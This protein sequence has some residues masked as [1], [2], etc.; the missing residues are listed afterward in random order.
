MPI[1]AEQKA[2]YP[3]DWKAISQR[4]RER[5]ENKCKTCKAPNGQVV[6][7]SAD[8]T[9][10]M[11]EEGQ[12]FSAADGEFL[13][14]CKGSEYNGGNM[15][16]IVLTVAH[17]DHDP[18]NNADDNLAALCQKCHLA[19]DAEHHKANANKTRRGRKAIGELF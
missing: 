2:L 4:I 8:G 16:K 3:K 6:W 7:R 17:L 19:Y 18:A 13:G 14:M 5:E 11:L 1:R 10:Y 9:R 15:V 12:V